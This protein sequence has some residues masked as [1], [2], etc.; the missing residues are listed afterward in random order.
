MIEFPKRK[1]IRLKDY[2]YSQP[3]AYFVTICIKD[4]M[5]ILGNIS[6]GKIQLSKRGAIIHEYWLSIPNHFHASFIR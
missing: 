5:I 6:D 3:G 1:H 4:K 2:D